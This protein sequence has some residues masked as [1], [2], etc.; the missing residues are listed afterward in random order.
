MTASTQPGSERFPTLLSPLVVGP[1][2]IRNRIVSTGHATRLADGQQAGPRL[3]AYHRARAAGGVGLIVTEASFITTEGSYSGAQLVNTDDSIIPSLTALAEEVHAEGATIFG[4]LLHLGLEQSHRLDGTR[5]AAPGP[6]AGDSERYH[7]SGRAMTVAEIAGVV[8]AFAA[9]AGRIRTAGLDGVEIGA[10]HGYLLAQ[11]LSPEIN[12]RTD[13]YGGSF[14]GRL[15]FLVEVLTAVRDR[16][17]ADLALG[18]RISGDEHTTD[19][20]DG[21]AVVEICAAVAALAYDGRPLLDYVNVPIGS[22]RQIAGAVHIVSPMSTDLAISVPIAERISAAISQPVL[23]VGRINHPALAEEVLASGAAGL[24]GMTRALIVDPEM[25]AKTARGEVAEVRQCIACNQACIDRFH[26]GHGISCIQHPETGRETG[27]GIRRPAEAP[28][29]VLVVGGGPAGMKAACVAAERG[30]TVTLVE[31]DTT[32][33]GQVRLAERLPRRS[34][35]GGIV[36][37]FEREL[38]RAGVEV[39]LGETVDRDLVE[40]CGPDV[41]IVATGAT[42]RAPVGEL[43]DAHVVDAWQVLRGEA[44]VGRRVLVADARCDAI[45]IG[46]AEHLAGERHRVTL[47]STG[48]V[49]GET[50]PRYVRDLALGELHRLEV[51]QIPLVRLFGADDDTVYLQHMASGLPVIV[52]DIDTVVVCQGHTA[53]D[54]LVA[55]L[56]GDT[57]GGLVI[58]GRRVE[59]HVIGDARA[60]RTVEEATLEALEVASAI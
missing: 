46:I 28:K 29:R 55:E 48:H 17:G 59:V 21:D 34:E 42:V 58:D 20:L 7:T 19:G 16:I 30:H 56:G 32:L 13:A 14:E 23:A 38:V 3:R 9:A 39:R 2:T 15:R 1:V 57:D 52:T 47:A 41:V 8:E 12:R 37:N 11:F 22:S 6:S 44:E 54:G 5:V 4:Q 40:R 25:P 60:P 43:A 31:R 27:L 35:L 10:S 50:L 33:G 36:P 49:A 26:R 18:I 53:V 51:T 24:V 45:G